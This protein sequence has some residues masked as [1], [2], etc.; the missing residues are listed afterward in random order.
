MRYSVPGLTA[1]AHEGITHTTGMIADAAITSPK[2]STYI[3]EKILVRKFTSDYTLTRVAR[4]SG[5]D[6]NGAH[7]VTFSPDGKYLASACAD[8][9]AVEI[10]N[11]PDLSRVA[12]KSGADWN[13]AYGVAFSPDGKYLGAVS[14]LANAVEIMNVPDLSRVARKSGADWNGAHGVAFSPD[15][16]YLASTSAFANAVEIMK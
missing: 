6:W 5:A 1:G 8:A 9:D 15:G 16:K 4:K 11:V 3:L 12:R 2:I 14:V 13:Y 7:G 10:M